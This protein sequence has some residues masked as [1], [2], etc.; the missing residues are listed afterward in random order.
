M[1]VAKP[2]DFEDQSWKIHG[3]DSQV[4]EISLEPGESATCE[5]G[6]MCYHSDDVKVQMTAASAFGSAFTGEDIFK[7]KYTN[8]GEERGFVAFTA[9]TPAT[10]VPLDLAAYPEGFLVKQGM[11]FAQT[12]GGDQVKIQMGVSPARTCASC[13]CAGFGLVMQSIEPG[14]ES[15]GWAFLEAS[16][17]VLEKDLAD[18]ESLVISTGWIYL[19]PQT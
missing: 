11:Y 12:G 15:G 5:P 17:T 10:I 9:N 14:S 13:C 4:V 19:C 3:T 18:G 7:P 6:A 2:V 1:Q 16:G 8:K